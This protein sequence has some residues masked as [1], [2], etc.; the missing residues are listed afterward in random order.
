M[1]I[2]VHRFSDDVLLP[3]IHFYALCPP[4]NLGIGGSTLGYHLSMPWA[5]RAILPEQ[6]LQIVFH[7][8][9]NLT[10]G[11]GGF[12]VSSSRVFGLRP[13]KLLVVREKKPLVPRVRGPFNCF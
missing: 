1:C 6:H 7:E 8:N 9:R 11:A 4:E 10:L 2:S 13:T 5:L 12:S 3:S